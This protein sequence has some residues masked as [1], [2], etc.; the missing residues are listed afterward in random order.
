MKQITNTHLRI[1]NFT[2]DEY[3]AKFP[4]SPT[5]TSELAVL[6][7]KVML[8]KNKGNARDDAK[9]RMLNDN[10][11]KDPV[12]ATNMG[13]TRSQ[14]IANRD[15]GALK[16]LGHLPTEKEKRLIKIFEKL[17]IPLEYVGDGKCWIE[18]LCPDFIN[19]ETKVILELD[20]DVYAHKGK[21]VSK[22]K[23]YSNC[24]YQ[25]I[26]LTNIDEDHIRDWVLPFFNGGF[27]WTK[28][29][30]ITK[31]KTTGR[32]NVYNFEAEPN[33]TY[34][35]NKTV[36]HNCFANAFR[37]TL[38]TS[39]F[40][41]SRSMGLRH[42][43]PEHYKR[44]LDKLFQKRGQTPSGDEVQRAICKEIPLRFGIRFEDFLPIEGTKKISLELL[45]YLAQTDYPVM[46]NTKSDLVGREDYLKALSDNKGKSAVHVTLI[47]S[48]ND[49]LRKLEPGAPPYE[50]RLE[51]IRKLSGAGIRVVARIE[52]YMAF[53]NDEKR[54]VDKYIED[55]LKAGCRDITLDTYHISGR[56]TGIQRSYYKCGYDFQ[57]MFLVTTDSQPIGSLLLGKYMDLFRAKGINCSTFDL[58]NVTSN[59]D[60][61]CCS[62][63]D[64]FKTNSINFGSIVTA[65]RY[66]RDRN[67][68]PVTWNEYQGWV[69]EQGGFL[70][71]RLRED[72]QKLWNVE[73]NQM[74]S[75]SW[76]A[77]I[78]PIGYDGN[79]IYKYNPDYDYRLEVLKG[80]I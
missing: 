44:E 64:W 2:F 11:M 43:N 53:I 5:L 48:N 13:R 22:E 57:K 17:N 49:I 80:L 41:N 40:D 56:T 38:Y 8:G 28:I 70:S 26:W 39:F 73:G 14:K 34:I 51:C 71:E 66:V 76:A 77:N 10:P 50:K 69:E 60:S 62:V 31:E 74:F 65:I 35:A 4:N 25:T 15:I 78:E 67:G 3:R 52:P 37:A 27:K 61:N 6:K 54:D 79:F 18:N 7:S 12:V 55:L 23:I 72:V 1:H 45:K 9:A 46:I 42:C 30:K 75:I 24:G 33:N 59:D 16:N 58:G 19:Y 68:Q 47:S 36:V 21:I 29:K 63:G 20:L 32:K